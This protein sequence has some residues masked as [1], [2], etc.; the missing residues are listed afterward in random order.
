MYHDTIAH[1]ACLVVA[2]YLS[3]R[4]HGTCHGTHFR[5]MIDLTH[6]NLT[7]HDFLLHLVQ[8]TDHG[9]FHILDGIVNDGVGVDF[10]AFL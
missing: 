9:V 7:G 8:H 3:F 1:E 6:L 5:D 10:H 4:D 2:V